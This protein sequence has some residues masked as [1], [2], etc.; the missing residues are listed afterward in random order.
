MGSR[1]NIETQIRIMSCQNNEKQ[2]QAVKILS[3][4]KMN[5]KLSIFNHRVALKHKEKKKENEGVKTELPGKDGL[6]TKDAED[7]QYAMAL[8]ILHMRAK[9]TLCQV[10]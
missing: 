4:K 10:N 7:Q 1:K 2:D 3:L 5:F 8:G 9:Q 6:S